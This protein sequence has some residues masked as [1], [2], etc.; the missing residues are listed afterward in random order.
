MRLDHLLSK[1][2]ND[3]SPLLVV[4]LP[5]CAGDCPAPG[6]LGGTSIIWRC[7]VCIVVSTCPPVWGWWK[8]GVCVVVLDALLGPEG[9][10]VCLILMANESLLSL[11]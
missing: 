7:R 4:G 10:G 2:H 9:S 8:A 1:E 6:A 11:S 5:W 3:G